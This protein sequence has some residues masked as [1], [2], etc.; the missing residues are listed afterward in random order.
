MS[1]G[2]VQIAGPPLILIAFLAAILVFW[3]IVG[4]GRRP[5][6]RSLLGF[7]LLPGQLSQVIE[8]GRS[9]PLSLGSGGM[10]G[11]D[12]ATTLAGLAVLEGLADETAATDAPPIVT[13]AD[14][15][16]LAMAQDVLRRAYAQQGNTAGLDFRSVRYVAA[17]PLPYAAGVMDLLSNEET[18]TSVMAGVFG[19][20]AAF[21]AEEG[22]RQGLIQVAG[23]ADLTSQA[24]LYPSVTH[25]AIGEEMYAAGAYLNA[26]PAS[27]ASL[28][29]QDLIRLILII[30]IAVS[31]F[32]QLVVLL[33]GSAR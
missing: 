9:L 26:K 7:K 31:G 25:L 10:G 29:A 3:G 8:E 23:V 17:S 22:S 5:A 12:T 19:S 18:G 1:M 4:R 30:G 13:V 27:V 33:G 16:T 24:V 32:A 14:P 28:L 20:E 15:T 6:L 11:T 2:F 21:I